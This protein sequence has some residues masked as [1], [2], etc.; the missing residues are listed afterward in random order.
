MKEITNA[1]E[2]SKQYFGEPKIGYYV[3]NEDEEM[4]DVRVGLFI[5]ETVIDLA[6]GKTC[7]IDEVAAIKYGEDWI[8]LVSRDLFEE[9]D[10]TV[11]FPFWGEEVEDY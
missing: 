2:V 6:T 8:D 5:G 10:C 7:G 9:M 1:V 11:G 4:E 3:L